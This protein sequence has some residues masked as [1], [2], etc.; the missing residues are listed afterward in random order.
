MNKAL[1]FLIGLMLIAVMTVSFENKELKKDIES[2]NKIL[3]H[4]ERMTQIYAERYDFLRYQIWKEVWIYPY[5]KSEGHI[6]PLSS[7]D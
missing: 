1:F 2:I 5:L 3:S 7:R 6:S 4:R